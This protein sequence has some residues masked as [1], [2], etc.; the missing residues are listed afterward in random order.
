MCLFFGEGVLVS[1]F[2]TATRRTAMSSRE[3]EFVG[4]AAGM[5]EGALIRNDL[6]SLGQPKHGV[7][8]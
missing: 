5:T 4:M 2:S 1:F 3:A 6:M 7:D 8:A